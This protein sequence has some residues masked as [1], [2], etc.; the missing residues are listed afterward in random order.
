MSTWLKNI[1]WDDSVM[2]G[3]TESPTTMAPVTSVPPL[4]TIMPTPPPPTQNP[5][6]P[7]TQPYGDGSVVFPLPVSPD[8]LL[9]SGNLDALNPITT[10]PAPTPEPTTMPPTLPPVPVTMPPEEAP[11]EK[12]FWTKTKIA[13]A[14][15]A[16]LVFVGVV[17]F[18]FFRKSK[19]A[20]KNTSGPNTSNGKSTN[21]NVKSNNSM[22]FN[23]LL[24]NIPLNNVKKS[25]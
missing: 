15:L 4:E 14:V 5:N 7:T 21:N 18:L 23:D 24:K 17:Y 10:T 2:S 12:P 13:I 22:S 19:N 8:L 6:Y 25:K 11:E 16:V 1:Q 3:M 20:N 9:G